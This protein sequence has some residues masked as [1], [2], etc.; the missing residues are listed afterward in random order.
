MTTRILREPIVITER[1]LQRFHAKTTSSSTGCIL[2]TGA[3]QRSGYG[4]FGLDGKKHET[5]V[6]AWRL[7]HNGIPVPLGQLICHQCDCRSCVNPEHL[8]LGTSA[9]NMRHAFRDNRG[10]DFTARGTDFS[11]AILNDDMV[12]QIRASYIPG[13]YSYRKIAKDLG[14]NQHIVRSVILGKTWKHVDAVAE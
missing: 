12:R 11:T 7:A 14:V 1:L 3:V 13:R 5:H 9:E 10:K 8:K 6:L 2:W 4:A